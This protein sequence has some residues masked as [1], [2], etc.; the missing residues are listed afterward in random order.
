MAELQGRI[1]ITELQNRFKYHEPV[2][3]QLQ[4][5]DVIRATCLNLATL[6]CELCPDSRERSVSLTKLDEVMYW[7]NASIA[8]AVPKV[9]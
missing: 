5:Y 7:A 1:T 6:I 2:G 4:R 8:R 9:D 3:D